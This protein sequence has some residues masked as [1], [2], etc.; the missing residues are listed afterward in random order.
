MGSSPNSEGLQN[1]E[2]GYQLMSCVHR[3]VARYNYLFHYTV[4]GNSVTFESPWLDILV[5]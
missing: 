3:L 2:A 4:Q 5:T 1:K